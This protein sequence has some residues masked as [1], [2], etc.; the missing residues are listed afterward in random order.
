MMTEVV[1]LPRGRDM[2][3]ESFGIPGDIVGSI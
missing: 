3:E 2:E 1:D